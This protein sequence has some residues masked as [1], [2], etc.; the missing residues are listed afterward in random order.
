VLIKS[1]ALVGDY[2]LDQV[3]GGAA[4]V[5]K[6]MVEQL[7]GRGM[8][9]EYFSINQ[10]SSDWDRLVE[11]CFDG[12][13]YSNLAGMT[14]AQLRWICESGSPYI[15]FRHDIPSIVY[16][17]Q[18]AS[19]ELKSIF[20]GLF[21]K[22]RCTIFI[23]ELQKNFYSRVVDLGPNI[24][25]PPPASFGGFE[26]SGGTKRSGL[27]YLGPV[28]ESRGL[29]R[30]LE[31][32]GSNAPGSQVDIFGRV[33]DVELAA[34][35]Y[36]CGARLY[37]E[38]PRH[39]VPQLMAKYEGLV[40]HP[41]IIDSFCIKVVEAELC[42]MNLYVDRSRIGRFSYSATAADL[43]AFMASQSVGRIEAIIDAFF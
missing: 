3:L 31:W 27:L 43:S 5:D 18:S 26:R 10:R 17:Y 28:S 20:S 39:L 30:S 33:E 40:Y 1:I 42:G 4:L 12:V 24:I 23:S 6:Y 29:R 19:T 13:V 15:L 9:V 7:R 36:T 2:K 16:D 8:R 22:A 34:Y 35:A 25:L 38:L 37:P 41:N 11:G 32:C 14:I 21:K